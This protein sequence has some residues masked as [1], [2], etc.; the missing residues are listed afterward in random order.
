MRSSTAII[1]VAV[2]VSAATG[3][4]IETSF[5]QNLA[6]AV[7]AQG[8]GSVIV[9][10]GGGG[11]VGRGNAIAIIQGGIASLISAIARGVGLVRGGGFDIGGGGG[12]ASG[13]GA[14]LVGA[15]NFNSFG[16]NTVVTEAG[17][18][19]DL[20]AGG[21]GGDVGSEQGSGS[22]FGFAS[23]ASAGPGNGAA[24]VS[25]GGS[26]GGGG[27]GVEGQSRAGGLGGGSAGGFACNNC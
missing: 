6:G 21:G 27:G 19:V 20:L 12:G 8:G 7:T 26:G 18:R 23:A 4:V 14:G 15:S 2:C 11:E 13:I 1:F 17:G 22:G 16:V 5:R 3:A 10:G 25:A 24:S 9:F